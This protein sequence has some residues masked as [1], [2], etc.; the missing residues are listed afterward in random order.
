MFEDALWD[1]DQAISIDATA[2]KGHFRRALVYIAKLKV[3][4][5]KEKTGDFWVVEKAQ[6]FANESQAS[7]ARA[8]EHG[9]TEDRQILRAKADLERQKV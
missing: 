4:L 5:E 3:E 8:L 6:K 7:L 2:V 1:C 9:A